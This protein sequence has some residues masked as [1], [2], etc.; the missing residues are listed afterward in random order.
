MA[1]E[2]PQEHFGLLQL[3]PDSCDKSKTSTAFKAYSLDA[4]FDI[5][6][7][8][9][10]N[11]DREETWTHTSEVAHNAGGKIRDK[12]KD[13]GIYTARGRH[14]SRDLAIDG[15]N[16]MRIPVLP[17]NPLWL[18][19]F[20]KDDFPNARIYTFGYNSKLAFNFGTG[21][22]DAFARD[23]LVNIQSTRETENVN[24]HILVGFLIQ[25]TVSLTSEVGKTTPNLVCLPQYGRA[26]RQKGNWLNLKQA[27]LVAQV[28]EYHYRNILE[29]TT[30]VFFLGT[31]HAGSDYAA[32]AK[33]FADIARVVFPKVLGSVRN[34]L[35]ASLERNGRELLEL[36]AQFRSIVDKEGIRVFSF[37][38]Q[39]RHPLLSS[40]I[41]DEASATL[42]ASKEEVIPV[43]G[44][45]T[46][47]TRYASLD[48]NVYV[49]VRS[50]LR[51]QVASLD[52]A[53]AH[54]DIPHIT[55]RQPTFD[56]RS[57]TSSNTEV[58]PAEWHT[59]PFT[60]SRHNSATST[61]SASSNVS[62]ESKDRSS[63][64]HSASYLAYH[65]DFAESQG[66][67]SLPTSHKYGDVR[68][69]IAEPTLPTFPERNIST[70]MFLVPYSRNDHFINRDQLEGLR[71]SLNIDDQRQGRAALVGLGGAGKTEIAIAYAHQ[72]RSEHPDHSV[73]WIHATNY[74]RM[75]QDL[76][77]V[78]D[79]LDLRKHPGVDKAKVLRKWLE[80]PTNGSWLII[81]DNADDLR[82]FSE[83]GADLDSGHQGE[84]TLL[85]RYLPH[86]SHGSVLIT[87][88][89]RQIGQ[90]LVRKASQVFEVERMSKHEAL[91]L[92]RER[93][94]QGTDE[95]LHELAS[96]LEFLPLAIIQAAAFITSK[97]IPV[98]RYITLLKTSDKQLVDLLNKAPETRFDGSRP[99]PSVAA[100]WKISF[101]QIRDQ[102]PR[103]A[104]LLAVIS[105]FDRQK[106]P[107]EWLQGGQNLVEFE[108]QLGL[109]KAFS[110]V[111]ER[112]G[113]LTDLEMH[114][115]IQLMMRDW[116]VEQGTACSPADEALRRVSSHFPSGD[117]GTWEDCEK[118][119]AHALRALNDPM[120]IE[121]L[122]DRNSD[123][124]RASLR[125]KVARYF[126]SQNRFSE[127]EAQNNL[128]L[129]GLRSASDTFNE[130]I[131]R[132]ELQHV[133]ILSALGRLVTAVKFAEE[134]RKRSKKT[135]GE[136]HELT[137]RAI[138]TLVR[139]L[140][141]SGDYSEATQLAEAYMKSRRK[142]L[143]DNHQDVFEL[144]YR[145]ATLA[146]YRD[147]YQE[148][149]RYARQVIEGRTMDPALGAN[150][151]Q[152]LKAKYRLASTLSCQGRYREAESQFRVIIQSQK[153]TIGTE[154]H[155]TL[156]SVFFLARNLQF[157]AKFEEAEFLLRDLLNQSVKVHATYLRESK[158]LDE[159]VLRARTEHLP[160]GHP[161]IAASMSS[162]ATSERLLQNL[163]EATKRED[164][165]WKL[166]K[167]S[168]GGDHLVS[169]QSAFNKGVIY[170]D[171]G[172]LKDAAGWYEWVFKR[173]KKVLSWR[174]RDTWLSAHQLVQVLE[175]LGKVS[176]AKKIRQR[177]ASHVEE[178]P[179]CLE[180]T[181]QRPS[182]GMCHD[183][184]SDEE[185]DKSMK[186][187]LD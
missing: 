2:I 183:N 13:G 40:R 122:L 170:Q 55:Q 145:L 63:N 75:R 54:N 12:G 3:Y 104:D 135:F 66:A 107:V 109:L 184:V 7:L 174:H 21:R 148:A 125:S 151:P 103:A 155:D 116:L 163:D 86:A 144:I 15:T 138:E 38:E 164:A 26:G 95:D 36:S 102:N 10:L 133:A 152:T 71:K 89:S 41:V 185:E 157:L 124:R 51:Q 58:T 48:S 31:P 68:T 126:F 165:A 168:L 161:N 101:D 33:S 158:R 64:Y 159:H 73:F 172:R 146:E 120:M 118:N 76:I 4:Q 106:I 153:I 30:A 9:G 16:N 88:R 35:V 96:Q 150:H 46:Q 187:D 129:A 147:K 140:Q 22:L 27:L 186:K 29:S 77:A 23:L 67:L 53:K 56:D 49:I 111:T 11:G 50:K 93:E 110:L 117:F 167:S 83:S 43:H 141:N 87:S 119:L 59:R 72:Y 173:R 85:D 98:R 160:K 78:V 128:A 143:G 61:A 123:L 80:D 19:D 176:N 142:Q 90:R 131:L 52:N 114:R 149:E 121:I 108:D 82:P 113:I 5:F 94:L 166:A 105:F 139:A 177:M 70:P 180:W 127:A 32:V 6:A 39:D 97:S 132:A 112:S 42:G 8:H 182:S 171:Q 20:L 130:E 44:H 1:P 115:L 79:R 45:H 34:D 62:E 154:H 92:L 169:M 28:D 134:A 162:L 69:R 24:S 17:K 179:E 74:D 81:L 84:K 181:I 100:T 136:D 37:V 47:I 25:G 137:R 99:S 156:V 91:H 14:G 65:E 175:G 60:R 178:R 57:S 18:R